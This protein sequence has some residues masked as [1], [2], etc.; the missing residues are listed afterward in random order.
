MTGLPGD[1]DPLLNTERCS[2]APLNYT[3]LSVWMQSVDEGTPSLGEGKGGK[4]T[5]TRCIG[6]VFVDSVKVLTGVKETFLLALRTPWKIGRARN[7]P[8]K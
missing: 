8:E 6:V 2:S 1:L 3:F 4:G 7:L 5:L